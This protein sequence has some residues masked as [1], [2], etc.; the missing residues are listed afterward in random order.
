VYNQCT[1]ASVLVGVVVLLVPKLRLG[2]DSR[3]L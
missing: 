3:K 2:T 1:G